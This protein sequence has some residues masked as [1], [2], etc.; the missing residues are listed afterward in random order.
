MGDMKMM[1]E[2]VPP[3]AGQD[4]VTHPID[5]IHQATDSIPDAPGTKPV[6]STPDLSTDPAR[7]Q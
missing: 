2:P 1:E 3:V 7:I 5:N 4:T 6:D